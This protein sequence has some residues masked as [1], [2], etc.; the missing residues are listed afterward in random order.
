MEFD[1]D[2]VTGKCAELAKTGIY[3]G[4]SS[5]KYE[6]WL[7]QMY[8]PEA[9]DYRGKF[10]RTRFE[11]TCLSEYGRVFKTVCVDG[12]YYNFPSTHYLEGLAEQVP[13]DFKFGF[14]VTDAITIKKFPRLPRFGERAGKW[15]EHFLNADLFASAFLRPCEA[16]RDKVG[17]VIFEFS[18]FWASDYQ[19]GKDFIADLD[20][21]LGD[22]PKGWPYG[23]EIRNATWLK[24]EYFDVLRTHNITHVF[25]SWEAMPSV[26]EQFVLEGSVTTH[27]RVAARFLLKPG[28]KYEGAVKAFS[29]YDKTKE[30]YQDG[31]DIASWILQQCLEE[32]R[33]AY[34]Y[35]NNRFEGNAPNTIDAILRPFRLPIPPAESL[36]CP[37]L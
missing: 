30:I 3:I 7:G 25:N 11:R 18:R 29:P 37:G 1:R 36:R 5:W 35:V 12:A 21:F 32:K 14:K 8:H 6:G 17:I 10:A 31:R 22:L 2:A 24:P 13:Y 19:H 27:Q 4:T 26:R 33:G 16:I 23:V 15:N 20:S 34:I 9:Y 28:T